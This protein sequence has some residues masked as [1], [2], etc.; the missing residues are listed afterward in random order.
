MKGLKV[1]FPKHALKIKK[2]KEKFGLDILEVHKQIAREILKEE[3]TCSGIVTIHPRDRK[4][5]NPVRI[6][7]P[8]LEED[9]N[10]AGFQ[11]RIVACCESMFVC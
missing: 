7:L 1:V 10:Q 2:D 9:S 8:F 4:F 11:E 6:T 3:A 5:H